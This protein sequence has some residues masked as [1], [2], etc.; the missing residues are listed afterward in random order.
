MRETSSRSS[1]SRARWRTC[2]SA[3]VPRLLGRRGVGARQ[4]QQV[5]G[6]EE[7]RQG[8]AELVR[9]HG[10]E[11]VLAAV[12]LADLAV[13][14]RVVDEL[15]GLAGV[16]LH[17]ADLAVGG[18]MGPGEEGGDGPDVL[19]AAGDQGR[20]ARRADS[21]RAGRPAGAARS[22]G[23][24]SASSTTRPP[25]M[26]AVP[27]RAGRLGRGRPRGAVGRLRREAHAGRRGH[28]VPLAVAEQQHAPVR[29]LEPR[30]RREDL[31]QDL[32]ELQAVG[33]PRAQ[34]VQARH[35]GQL[36]R[37]LVPD[38]RQLLLVLLALDRRGQD[39]GDGLQEVD[40]VLREGPRPAR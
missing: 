35:V 30:D 14:P 23:S 19:P 26:T 10:Q 4:P 3:I 11:L 16:E 24:A 9:E 8:V 20:A 33:E 22:T 40:V 31:L 27:R 17:Q 2:R 32:L 37:Q 39:V 7:R 29:P 34:G 13:Q 36:D 18:A 25:L 6:A 38:R 15:G 1:T 12:G 5:Q 21:R 28:R